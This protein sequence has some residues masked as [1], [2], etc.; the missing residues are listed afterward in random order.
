[1]TNNN[2]KTLSEY[3]HEMHSIHFLDRYLNPSFLPII[4]IIIIIIFF[5]EP[6]VKMGHFYGDH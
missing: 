4:I 6:M 2:N 5:I 3:I 1:M